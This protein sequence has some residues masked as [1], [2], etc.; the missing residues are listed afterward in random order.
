MLDD[1]RNAQQAVDTLF[2]E[3]QNLEKELAR[4]HQAWVLE[5]QT[6]AQ[7]TFGDQDQALQEARAEAEEAREAL[8]TAEQDLANKQGEIDHWRLR[9]E[10]AE[11]NTPRRSKTEKPR[12]PSPGRQEEE[13]E[14]AFSF[15]HAAA[16]NG[17]GSSRKNLFTAGPEP[18][19]LPSIRDCHLG[20]ERNQ[21]HHLLL[22]GVAIRQAQGL[23]EAR[24]QAATK[25]HLAAQTAPVVVLVNRR[26]ADKSRPLSWTLSL[27]PPASRPSSFRSTRRLLL[28]R[29]DRRFT[30]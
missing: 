3:A 12:G 7:P 19:R 10:E 8:L 29:S 11:N 9:A 20:R 4:R 18:L 24:V 21:V 30:A 13:N 6:T 17:V 28:H 23:A 2:A 26:P 22:L 1:A 5:Q 14:D 25:I 16:N 27:P 15:S